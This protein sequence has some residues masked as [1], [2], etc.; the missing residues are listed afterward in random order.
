V[1]SGPW[2]SGLRSRCAPVAV[3]DASAWYVP[4]GLPVRVSVSFGLSP[5][6]TESNL[7]DKSRILPLIPSTSLGIFDDPMAILL[8]LA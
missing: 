3:T 5:Q 7:D 8:A 4:I 2:S 1:R 6:A